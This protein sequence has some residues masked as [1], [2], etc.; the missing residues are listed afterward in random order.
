MSTI[1]TSSIF[2]YTRYFSNLKSILVEGLIPNFCL[3]TFTKDSSEVYT[4]GIPMVS[5]CDIPLTRIH[6][7]SRYGFYGIGLSKKWAMYNQVNPILYVTS[8]LLDN[9]LNDL[10]ELKNNLEKIRSDFEN[11][12]VKDPETGRNYVN[13]DGSEASKRIVEWFILSKYSYDLHMNLFGFSKRAPNILERN[14][15]YEENEWRYLV[16]NSSESKWIWDESD[17]KKW[18]GPEEYPSGRKTPKPNS[19]ISPLT[20]TVDDINYI[21]VKKEK[22]IPPLIDF[23]QE[24]NIIGGSEKLLSDSDKKILLTKIIS[25]EVIDHDF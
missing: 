23:I 17:Y 19:G 1:R 10:I 4:I 21:I 5:F 11:D 14:S 9:T 7:F 8:R 2:H 25:L 22:Q 15:V 12:F 24:L 13:I 20:F 3:E 18:R 6:Y 16:S